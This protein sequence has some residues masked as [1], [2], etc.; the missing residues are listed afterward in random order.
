LRGIPYAVLALAVTAV[1]GYLLMTLQ[2]GQREHIFVLLYLPFLALRVHRR[3]GGQVGL[4]YALTVGVLAG[5][6]VAIKPYFAL[7]AVLVEGLGLVLS[8]RWHLR[9]PEVLGVGL[10]AAAHVAYFALNPEV[11]AAFIVLIGRLQAGYGAYI[12]VPQDEK[13]R[14][15]L[16]YLSIGVTTVFWLRLRTRSSVLPNQYAMAMV[17]LL[18][19]STIGYIVQ[20]KGWSYHAIPMVFSG[21]ILVMGFAFELIEHGIKPHRARLMSRLGYAMALAIALSAIILATSAP[22][23]MGAAAEHLLLFHF[24]PY[25]ERYSQPRERVMFLDTGPGPAYPMLSALNR[26][27]ASRYLFSQPLPLSYYRSEGVPYSEVGHVPPAYLQDY[28]SH[29]KADIARHQPPLIIIRSGN[30]PACRT[31]S[32]IVNLYDFLLSQ[33]VIA[34]GILPNYGVLTE[35]LGFIVYVRRDLATR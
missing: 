23:W 9:T 17:A 31:Q 5:V 16:I 13:I 1:S 8:R 7:T 20:G 3:E 26:R 35:E 6:G 29:L 22:R 27:N 24:A 18:V 28:V 12:P 10:V 15:T 2:W 14:T 32:G 30:C 34:D 25:V 19:G 4:L 21:A 33:D 11:L